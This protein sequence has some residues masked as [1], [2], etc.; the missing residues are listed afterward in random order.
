MNSAIR[1]L[2]GDIRK[3]TRDLLPKSHFQGAH[4]YLDK[5]KSNE[6]S[7]PVIKKKGQLMLVVDAQNEIDT[8]MLENSNGPNGVSKELADL[9]FLEHK[10]GTSA[11]VSNTNLESVES[12]R[13][14]NYA[15][16]YQD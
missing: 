7:E 2:G 6:F 12:A 1:D 15:R 5:R 14:G 13:P 4:V 11:E 9:S 3:D 8:T 16:N 10:N